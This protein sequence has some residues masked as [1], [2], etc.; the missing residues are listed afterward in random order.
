MRWSSFPLLLL[1]FSCPVFAYHA[2]PFTLFTE[3]DIS[4]LQEKMTD[5]NGPDDAA[6]TRTITAADYYL[7]I[8]ES[9]FFT[10][11]SIGSGTP[12]Y[13]QLEAFAYYFGDPAQ[14]SLYRDKCVAMATYLSDNFHPDNMVTNNYPEQDNPW[15]LFSLSL[16]Y[17]MCY[18]EFAADS[19]QKVALRTEIEAYLNYAYNVRTD[20]RNDINF[21]ANGNFHA[22]IGGSILMGG[23]VIKDDGQ[24]QVLY[25]DA[26]TLGHT[27]VQGYI[28]HSLD[29]DGGCTEGV[30]Y[31]A[32]SMLGL[33]Y[34]VIPQKNYDGTDFFSDP[35]V[36]KIL[37]YLAYNAIP[38]GN[39]LFHNWND[40][41][42]YEYS[43]ISSWHMF[44]TYALTRFPTPL[45]RFVHDHYVGAYPQDPVFLA[46]F[47]DDVPSA[48]IAALLPDSALFSGVGQYFYRSGWNFGGQSNDLHFTFFSGNFHRGHNQEDK[49]TFSLIGFKDRLIIDTGDS[50]DAGACGDPASML[51]G[52]NLILINPY[53]DYYDANGNGLQDP[54]ETI[55]YM[56]MAKS[57][58]NCGTDGYIRSSLITQGIDML[59]G[60]AREAYI[61]NNAEFNPF[62]QWAW[63]AHKYNEGTTEAITCIHT[64]TMDRANRYFLVIK[65]EAGHPGYFVL[66]DDTRTSTNPADQ[67]KFLLH[68]EYKDDSSPFHRNSWDT[69]ANPLRVLGEH[70]GLLNV[71]WVS[72]TYTTSLFANSLYSTLKIPPYYNQD[73]YNRLLQATLT[74]GNPQWFMLFFPYGP[75]I[76]PPSYNAIAL[77]AGLGAKLTFPSYTD[78]VYYAP[79]NSIQGPGVSGTFKAAWVRE[80][81][82]LPSHYAAMYVRDMSKAGRV[83]ISV[84]ND[85]GQNPN[86]ASNGTTLVVDDRQPTYTVYGPSLVKAAYKEEA[87]PMYRAGDY[88]LVSLTPPPSCAAQGGDI[89]LAY[90]VCPGEYIFSEDSDVCCNVQCESSVAPPVITNVRAAA[91]EVMA[92]IQWMTDI[93]SDTQVEYGL[94]PAHGSSTFLGPDLIRV[95]LVTINGLTPATTYHYRVKSCIYGTLCSFSDDATF[96]T[97]AVSCESSG[98]QC[99]A[100]CGLYADCSPSGMACADGLTCCVGSCSCQGVPPDEDCDG[101]IDDGELERSIDRWLQGMIPMDQMLEIMSW[102]KSS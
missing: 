65:P 37:S 47:G 74:S 97:N 31:C 92:L 12:V 6:M 21:Y 34:G 2:H 66:A 25:Q 46:L 24:N 23:L 10:A 39:G 95:H 43:I 44:P 15:I 30:G 20:W 61:Q 76:V 54:G 96:T 27:A 33:T 51:E 7:S 52:H 102:W 71:Y 50:H 94:T 64:N 87:L 77:T 73:G 58:G 89:C 14:K 56:G 18:N 48:D 70:G 68:T 85:G 36:E 59:H 79:D 5:G 40:W 69:S 8:P 22:N 29:S 93:P 57:S 9:T 91:S 49:N 32:L 99:L 86:I 100:D 38:E 90:E 88:R 98:G 53:G 28:Q 78:E 35:R 1:L 4:R 75:T 17:D 26:I 72:P 13:V 45:A 19:P 62:P 67:Y 55:D 84:I 11:T 16:A 101:L 81:N 3:E 83:L 82:G 80:E 41:P 42:T 60:D 63:C